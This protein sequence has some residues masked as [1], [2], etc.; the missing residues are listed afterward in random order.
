MADK[1]KET[2]ATP[3][4]SVKSV[5]QNS[6]NNKQKQK[7]TAPKRSLGKIAKE[8]I[9]ELKKV[10]WPTFPKVVKQTGVVIVVVLTFAVVLLGFDT[11][12]SFL[13]N[14]LVKAIS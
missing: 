1:E 9:S 8:T 10:S 11:L 7:N 3:T 6:K 14:L 4:N 5:K 2:N 12:F 13:Y